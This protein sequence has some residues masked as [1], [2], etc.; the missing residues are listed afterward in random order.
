MTALS[1]GIA[2]ATATAGMR[3]YAATSPLETVE[4]AMRSCQ[5]ESQARGRAFDLLNQYGLL[6]MVVG[7][8]A[9]Y[10][11]AQ[12]SND[13]L[14]QFQLCAAQIIGRTMG[15]LS[16]PDTAT[17]TL[18]GLVKA[19]KA[20]KDSCEVLMLYSTT[21]GGDMFC[22]A[23]MPYYSKQ[24]E[25]EGALLELTPYQSALSLKSALQDAG[26]EV[27]IVKAEA[28]SSELQ[29]LYGMTES[30][31]LNSS[32]ISKESERKLSELPDQYG[33]L[34]MVVGIEAPYR[35]KQ[36]SNDLLDLFQLHAGQV[37]GRTMGVLTGPCTASETLMGL[38]KA[39]KASKE[40]RAV[41][42]LYSTSGAGDMFCVAC[43]PFYSKNGEVQGALL[44]LT[45]CQA[46][47][48]KNAAQDDGK[49]K[50]IVEVEEPNRTV[51]CTPE[52]EALYGLTESM[53]LGRSLNLIHGPSFD[54]RSWNQLLSSA[55]QGAS[56]KHML[57]TATSDCRE[58]E[59][60][61]DMQPIVSAAGFITHILIC[62]TPRHLP[63]NLETPSLCHLEYDVHRAP[64][65]DFQS[66][67]YGHPQMPSH[68]MSVATHAPAKE[69]SLFPL[70]FDPTYGMPAQRVTQRSGDPFLESAALQEHYHSAIPGP[71]T[72]ASTRQVGVSTVI[73]RRKAGQVADSVAMPVSITVET[74][75]LYANVPLA[76]AAALLGISSTA[77][78]KACR[79]LGVTRWPYTSDETNSA[80]IPNSNA[81][82]QVDAAYVRKLFRKYCA[83][84]APRVK[85]SMAAAAS[86]CILA[87]LNSVLGF[88][89]ITVPASTRSDGEAKLL[90]DARAIAPA[91]VEDAVTKNVGAV[92]SSESS[93][94]SFSEA[95]T[96]HLEHFLEAMKTQH[97][98]P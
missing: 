97:R 9:P 69:Q 28:H 98:I 65:R 58:I 82:G 37:I 59:T 10:R 30:M 45:P 51:F 2:P 12:V 95:L 67:T 87:P 86:E 84:P 73:P 75:K 22:V 54:R 36:V 63:Y 94:T 56:S 3:G 38:V 91:K 13:L 5:I 34:R 61:I 20:G 39:A 57:V 43:M 17:E 90:N 7:I 71:R 32:C 47:S 31:V 89:P 1:T 81:A 76:K 83:P 4:Q 15:V 50:V 96:P 60:M 74:L 77:M 11:I 79:R 33:L 21:S 53:V 42:M 29:A 40:A 16:G 18:M 55:R 41:L 48:L 66:D 88:P 35:I 64:A 70:S 25:V 62:A 85:D 78:K 19:A 44:E 52:F 26:E 14:D 49:A 27:D 68:A 72:Q 8:E 92:P 80:Q 24:G 23:C 6:R 93:S 46:P